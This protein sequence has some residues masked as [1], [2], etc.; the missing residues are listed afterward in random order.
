MSLKK[1]RND[2]TKMKNEM[3]LGNEPTIQNFFRYCEKYY[4]RKVHCGELWFDTYKVGHPKHMI[5]ATAQPMLF[6]RLSEEYFVK[7]HNVRNPIRDGQHGLK[8]MMVLHWHEEVYTGDNPYLNWIFE[9]KN[10]NK[11]FDNYWNGLKQ[12][13]DKIDIEN[14][15]GA[16]L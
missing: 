11:W 5:T 9:D 14:L 4:G 1:V 15:P 16:E 6:L 10:Y 13:F 12:E 2:I 3:G 8:G 7:K